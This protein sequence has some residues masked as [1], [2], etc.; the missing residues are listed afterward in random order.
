MGRLGDGERE[1]ASRLAIDALEP[2]A[3]EQKPG[4]VINVKHKFA[5]KRFNDEYLWKPTPEI[6]SAIQRAIFGRFKES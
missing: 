2:I 3:P 5:K 4:K 1:K 6:E